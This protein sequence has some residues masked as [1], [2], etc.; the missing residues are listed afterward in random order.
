MSD[1][2]LYLKYWYLK[3][4]HENSTCI[5]LWCWDERVVD[6]D[7]LDS[8]APML[9]LLTVCL[10]NHVYYWNNFIKMPKYGWAHEVQFIWYPLPM[11]IKGKK[12]FISKLWLKKNIE[13][14]NLFP[15][16]PL[17]SNNW[18]KNLWSQSHCN[19][20]GSFHPLE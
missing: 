18:F 8:V 17:L 9:W 7:P 5:P 1:Y 15:P 20:I 6:K 16:P 12:V 19:K 13:T 10:S 4:Y 14:S 3:F 11:D 2:R